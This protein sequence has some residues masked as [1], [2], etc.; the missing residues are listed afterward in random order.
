MECSCHAFL[1]LLSDGGQLQPISN[2]DFLISRLLPKWDKAVMDEW[3][4]M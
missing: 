2:E 1:D 3:G 4:Q